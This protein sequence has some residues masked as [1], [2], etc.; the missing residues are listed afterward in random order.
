MSNIYLIRHGKPAAAFGE[1][2]DPG[3]DETGHAQ[4]RAAAKA[5]LALP[6]AD[7]PTKVVSSPLKRC[8]ETAQPF[9]DALGVAVQIVPA[10]GEI[11]TP[12]HLGLAERPVWLREAFGGTWAQIQGDL[13]YELWRREVAAAVARMPATAVFSHFVAINAVVSVLSGDDKV[14][15]FRP[16]HTSITTLRLVEGGLKLVERGPEAQTGVL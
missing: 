7:R 5:L 2:D 15:G 4:A 14:I 13:D 11:P 1:D 16:D 12:A 10:V 9:A 6:E 3:L 8:R